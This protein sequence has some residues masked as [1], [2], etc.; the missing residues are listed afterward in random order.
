MFYVV[1]VAPTGKQ[2]RIRTGIYVDAAGAV[3]FFLSVPLHEREIRRGKVPVMCV[4]AQ[5]LC[6]KGKIDQLRGTSNS[7]LLDST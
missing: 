7:Q 2:R 6:Q 4:N 3:Y 1:S 5:T